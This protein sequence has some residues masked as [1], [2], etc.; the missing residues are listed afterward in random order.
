M[1]ELESGKVEWKEAY[2]GRRI[3]QDIVKGKWVE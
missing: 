1:N 2:V 3:R